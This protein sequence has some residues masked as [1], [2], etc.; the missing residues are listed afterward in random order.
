[1]VGEQL[2]D[3]LASAGHA[4]LLEHGLDVVT[5]G[6]GGEM[7]PGGDLRGPEPWAISWVICSSRNESS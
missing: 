2:G 1:V 5:H 7:E 3:E 4:D 6:V